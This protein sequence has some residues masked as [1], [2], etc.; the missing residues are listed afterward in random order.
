VPPPPAPPAPPY[1]YAAPP[2]TRRT[3][4]FAVAALVCSLATFVVCGIGSILGI[5]FGHVAR[6]QIKRTGEDGA[7]LAL[8]G[9]IIGYVC[10]G[11]AA[12]VIGFIIVLAAVVDH[13][14]AG[15]D[16]ARDVD[17]QIVTIARLRG[18]TPRSRAVIDQAFNSTCC[19]RN[20]TLGSTGVRRPGATDAELASVHWRLDIEGVFGGHVCL[21]VPSGLVASDGDVRKGRC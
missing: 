1:A 11:I 17:A 19:V 14:D 20:V 8:A 21:T 18:T 5:V 13:S 6:S 4:G 3:N 7:G 10:L 15:V 12:L 16:H 9:L 2:A